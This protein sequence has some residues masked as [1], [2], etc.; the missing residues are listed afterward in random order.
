MFAYYNLA[1]FFVV[2][3]LDNKEDSI[4]YNNKE[5]EVYTFT[6]E[7]DVEL[8]KTAFKNNKQIICYQGKIQIVDL[9]RQ[10][11]K[12]L[13][14]K[15]AIIDNYIKELE[16]VFYIKTSKTDNEYLLWKAKQEKI[17][18]AKEI[19]NKIE[20]E[21][22]DITTNN[23]VDTY[24]PSKEIVAV[25][26][27][28]IDFEETPFEFFKIS[29]KN[30]SI[31][32]PNSSL[33]TLMIETRDI[34]QYQATNFLRNEREI[35]KLTTLENIENYQIKAGKNLGEEVIDK[36]KVIVKITENQ[37]F[38]SQVKKIKIA[39]GSVET[40]IKEKTY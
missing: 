17:D 28:G 33:Q 37:L 30:E 22:I 19:F 36:V 1:Q 4:Y 10:V 16:G 9:E 8:F 23:V 27:E 18:L 24:N 31:L 12:L 3:I 21:I 15:F 34:L 32:L 25:F 7:D 2:D 6:A 39:E 5:Y 13:S 20:I 38:I 40:T 29:N 35:E 11:V 14:G 26:Q